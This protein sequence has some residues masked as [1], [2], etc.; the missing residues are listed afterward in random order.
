M[1]RLVEEHR[2]VTQMT[3]SYTQGLQNSFPEHNASKPSKNPRL[4]L[5][6]LHRFDL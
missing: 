4:E 6:L 1:G 3:S 5:Q 2:K